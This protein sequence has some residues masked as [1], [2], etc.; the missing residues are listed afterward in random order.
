MDAGDDLAF[1]LEER[2]GFSKR[3]GDLL[4]QLKA[5]FA[6]LADL[7]LLPEIELHLPEDDTCIR[8]GRL[9]V[10]H[11]AAY[12]VGVTMGDYYRVHLLGCISCGYDKVAKVASRGH[13]PL[14][15]ARIEQD[16]L[17][18]GVHERGNEMMLKIRC[19]Q[20]IHLQEAVHGFS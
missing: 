13:A 9:I 18:A 14:S 17:F 5:L 1:G 10:V 7:T 16:Q 2:P 11:Q 15:V 12:V 8:I 4:E 19:R 3:Y 20:A 6:S